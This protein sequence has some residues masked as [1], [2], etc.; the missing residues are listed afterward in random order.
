MK[1]FVPL[2]NK[3]VVC[4]AVSIRVSWP[5]TNHEN[6]KIPKYFFQRESMACINEKNLRNAISVWPNPLKSFGHVTNDNGKTFYPG[7]RVSEGVGR[8]LNNSVDDDALVL[9]WL[10][11]QKKVASY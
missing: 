7:A 3:G 8:G 4:C 9:A 5:P 2:E 11:E 10:A 6:H 1:E